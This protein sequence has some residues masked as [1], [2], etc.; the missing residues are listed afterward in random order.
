MTEVKGERASSLQ[1]QMSPC[2]VPVTGHI[3]LALLKGTTILLPALGLFFLTILL[4]FL[5]SL[6]LFLLLLLSPL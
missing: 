2:P 4:F 1:I 5:F 6:L 3:P